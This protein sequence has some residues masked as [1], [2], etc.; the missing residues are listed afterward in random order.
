MAH[1][2]ATAVEKAI[3]AGKR[4]CAEYPLDE[5]LVLAETMDIIRAQIGVK[6]VCL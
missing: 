4:E 5:S 1:V 2:Q 3:Q 6:S